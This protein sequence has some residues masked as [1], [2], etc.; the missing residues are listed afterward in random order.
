VKENLSNKI[1]NGFLIFAIIILLGT[2]LLRELSV[3]RSDMVVKDTGIFLIEFFVFLVTV[4][5]SSSYLIREHKEKSIYLILTKPVSRTE[6]IFGNLIG[7]IFMTVIYV[8]IMTVFLQVMLM[9]IGASLT[10]LELISILFIFIKLSILSAL[11]IF[12]AVISDS[13]V[14]ANIFTFSIYIVSHMT[15]ELVFLAEKSD[16]IVLKGIFKAF[17][18]ILPRLSTLNLRDYILPIE[19]NYFNLFIYSGVY[20]IIV[21]LITSI[22]FEK[23]KL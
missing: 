22:I 14:T 10:G 19:V 21:A 23:R 1:L 12:F 5:S 3:Y 4:F 9:A 6:Y 2:L 15:T 7:N 13:Y 17:Y 11:G 16:N 8:G 20:M 18:Y